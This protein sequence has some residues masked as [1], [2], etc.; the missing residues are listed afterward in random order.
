MLFAVVVFLLAMLSIRFQVQQQLR[1]AQYQIRGPLL[2]AAELGFYRVLREAVPKTVAVMS[3]VRV[4][5]IVTPKG[6]KNTKAWWMSFNAVSAKHVDFL[7][8]DAESMLPL[9]IVELD[10]KSHR[11]ASVLEKDKAKDIRIESSGL[12]VI[13]FTCQASYSIDAVRNELFK[14]AAFP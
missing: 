2:S 3:K 1:S 12:K 4:A 13:R 14:S 6:N 10:D 5:D 11:V 9:A 7:L 8:C